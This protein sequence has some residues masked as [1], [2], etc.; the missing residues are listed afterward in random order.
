MEKQPLHVSGMP[1]ELPYS[2]E[3]EQSVL[4]SVLIDVDCLPTV[5][6][7]LKA[8]CFYRRQH[9]DIFLIVQ[10]MFLSGDTVDFITV[11]EHVCRENIFPTDQDAKIYLTQLV[12]VVPTTANVSAYIRIVKDKYA[13]RSLISTFERVSTASREG[14]ADTG[15]LLEIAEQGIYD[16]RQGKFSNGLVHI[17]EALGM[18][19]DQL[20]RR[21]G[22][23]RSEYLGIPTG[24]HGLDRVIT[25]LN[26]SDLLI[27][28]ARPGMGKTSMALNIAINV[29]KQNKS[30]AI[31][32]LEMSKEQLVERL[33]SSEA[34]IPS[35]R[36]R[37]GMIER[38]Q[39]EAL[40]VKTDELARLPIYLDDTGS[41][42][43]SDV[44]AR[45]R[46][47]R[48]L[49]FIIIDYL[50]LMHGDRRTENRVQ[51]VS[52]MTR[53][54]KIMAK[55]LNIPV[56]VLSQL[57]RQNE[58]RGDDYKRPMLSDLRDSGSIEQDADIVLFLYRE[59]M[60]NPSTE[61][62]GIAE[63]IVSKNRHGGTGTVRLGWD[64]Q[65]TK[66]RNLEPNR[67]ES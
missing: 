26:K 64:G 62:P 32:S 17:S 28:A 14:A 67:D 52:E 46:R 58:R 29:A 63:C 11:L 12:Q 44:K 56:L 24:F 9:R 7:D 39:W 65:Y 60:Y 2:L 57:S 23:D 8:D 43:V 45:V 5:I 55:E 40:A 37:C 20:Q 22:E 15:E 3:A 51:E 61:E 50:Q 48:G 16:I 1:G 47:Q 19:L 33:L 54:L 53:S 38:D 18:A 42:T 36:L 49:S 13:L 4:G 31:F 10:Q 30:V 66:F 27:L 6:S 34:F 25:G 59:V 41:T 21:S 35:D